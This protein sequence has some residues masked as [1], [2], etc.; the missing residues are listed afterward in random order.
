MRVQRGI[1]LWHGHVC[2]SLVV[3]GCGDDGGGLGRLGTAGSELGGGGKKIF[4][5][6]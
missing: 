3:A 2:G 5:E 6:L 4:L 1:G